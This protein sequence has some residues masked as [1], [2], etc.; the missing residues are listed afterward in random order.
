MLCHQP[1]GKNT[2]VAAM[3]F[4]K[5][6]DRGYVVLQGKPLDRMEELWQEVK[7]DESAS[8]SPAKPTALT[9]CRQDFSVARGILGRISTEA[10]NCSNML[11]RRR[12]EKPV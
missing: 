8:K 4:P 12:S 10:E 11:G 2:G 1:E 9:R 5:G 7:Y 3:V 6:G